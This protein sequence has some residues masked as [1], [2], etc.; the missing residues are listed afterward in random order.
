MKFFGRIVNSFWELEN[1]QNFESKWRV[2]SGNYRHHKFWWKAIFLLTVAEDIQ[3]SEMRK[4]KRK[5]LILTIS[6]ENWKKAKMTRKMKHLKDQTKKKEKKMKLFHQREKH[7][8][9]HLYK[10]IILG[11]QK[12]NFSHS[13][14]THQKHFAPNG[15]DRFIYTDIRSEMIAPHTNTNTHTQKMLLM[16]KTKFFCQSFCFD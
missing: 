11:A 10:R 12:Q 9:K 6:I 15:N 16:Q 13:Q 5:L 4:S 14:N 8:N 1:N 3:M 7:P 2:L